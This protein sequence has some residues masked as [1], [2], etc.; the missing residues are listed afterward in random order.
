[1]NEER[2]IVNT[3]EEKAMAE[4]SPMGSLAMASNTENNI[5]PPIPAWQMTLTLVLPSQKPKNVYFFL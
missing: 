5:P 1:M 3:G 2:I 4:K